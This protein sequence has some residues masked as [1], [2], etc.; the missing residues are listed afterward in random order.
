MFASLASN[1]DAKLEDDRIVP[2]L[3]DGPQ[4]AENAIIENGRTYSIF[5]E[6]P[7]LPFWP[8]IF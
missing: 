6:R 1:C 5:C 7:K 4:A 2:M 8:T 3:R